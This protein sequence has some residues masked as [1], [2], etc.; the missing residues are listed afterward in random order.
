MAEQAPDPRSFLEAF[1][2]WIYTARAHENGLVEQIIDDA[3]AF[4]HPR[5][6][7]SLHRQ[8]DAFATHATIDRLGQITA[9]TLVIAGGHDIVTPPRLGRIVADA[10]PSARFE[11]LHDEAHQPF[12]EVPEQFNKLIESFWE[13][14]HRPANRA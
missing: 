10:I 8:I 4:P 13:E 2:V 7:E 12:Q 1:F 14:V 5:S 6:R 9:P 3:L 11:L